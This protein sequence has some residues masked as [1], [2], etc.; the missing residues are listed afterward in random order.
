MLKYVAGNRSFFSHIS[1]AIELGL[2]L[3]DESH[4]VIHVIMLK[5]DSLLLHNLSI[6]AMM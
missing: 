4:A 3:I 5:D 1:N 6:S 2:V